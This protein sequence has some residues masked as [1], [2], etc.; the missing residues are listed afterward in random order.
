MAVVVT[1]L[2]CGALALAM[3]P[4]ATA[5]PGRMATSSGPDPLSAN[6]SYSDLGG[7]WNCGQGHET[8]VF[9]SNVAGGVEPYTY[10]WTFGDG[11]PASAM[12][13]PTH[14]F[15]RFAQFVVNVSIRDS[16][17][18]WLN[19]SV[20]PSWAIPAACAGSTTW[21][22]PLGVFGVALYI[23][24]LL[25][26]VLGAALVYRVRRRRPWPSPPDRVDGRGPEPNEPPL[27]GRRS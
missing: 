17:G 7:A 19:A 9:F 10:N 3:V 22:G 25:A 26:L 13:T 18:A 20:S 5:A 15:A 24:L 6:L 11:S 27:S 2:L 4:G 21:L 14:T 16:T 12:A 8:F 1:S 23:A